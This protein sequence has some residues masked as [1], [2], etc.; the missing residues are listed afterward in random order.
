MIRTVL[1]IML[2]LIAASVPAVCMGDASEITESS[3]W[4]N[5]VHED[6]SLV[7]SVLYLPYLVIQIPYRIIEGV[8]NPKPTSQS[9]IP[10]P[11]HRAH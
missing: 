4:A 6:N 10:P 9:T 1:V 7:A 11:A 3:Y 2:C 8:V 5:L